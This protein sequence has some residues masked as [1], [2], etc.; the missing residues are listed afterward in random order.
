MN[1]YVLLSDSGIHT[2]TI[3]N[4]KH[5]RLLNPGSSGDIFGISENL[6]CHH[7]PACSKETIYF[8]LFVNDFRLFRLI[9]TPFVYSID[10]I[11]G[12]I[13]GRHILGHAGAWNCIRNRGFRFFSLQFL[14]TSTKT[15]HR[16][17]TFNLIATAFTKVINPFTPFNPT[18]LMYFLHIY[19]HCVLFFIF[20]VFFFCD[21]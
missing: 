2:F 16:H 6:G 21:K 3:I 9:Y 14:L 13:P 7:S 4:K 8:S 10:S 5:R 19:T 20:F 11:G 17:C 12:K 18:P 15:T 1:C